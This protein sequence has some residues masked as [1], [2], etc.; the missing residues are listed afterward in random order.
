M[1][2][3]IFI[4]NALKITFLCKNEIR[5]T[6]SNDFDLNKC[7]RGH[8][9]EQDSKGFSRRSDT[10]DNANAGDVITC[11]PYNLKNNENYEN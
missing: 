7:Y 4:F 5:G 3:L 8:D 2:N 9:H 11:K 1:K 10:L 6:I